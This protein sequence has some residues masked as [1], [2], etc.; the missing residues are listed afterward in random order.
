M[1]AWQ[2]RAT[3][4]AVACTS[5]IA[6]ACMML[7]ANE[8]ASVDRSVADAK[9]RIAAFERA[10]AS[11]E[12]SRAKAQRD[13]TAPQ[14]ECNRKCAALRRYA[15]NVNRS[16]CACDSDVIARCVDAKEWERCV[17]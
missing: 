13:A 2:S 6:I 12:Q 9:A 15:L 1:S 10:R 4:Y 3:P 5:V 11:V 17:P 8:L 16:L 7:A 14:L